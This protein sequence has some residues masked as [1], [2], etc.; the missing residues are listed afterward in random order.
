MN[1]HVRLVGLA[2]GPVA[3]LVL[4]RY[5]PAGLTTYEAAPPLVVQCG[6]AVAP[7][8]FEMLLDLDN[9]VPTYVQ[10]ERYVIV[11]RRA[12]RSSTA[13]VGETTRAL[14]AALESTW[15]GWDGPVAV[16]WV[17][18][19]ASQVKPWATDQRLRAAGLFDATK[20]MRHARDAARHALFAACHDA[21]VPDPLGFR[22]TD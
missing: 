22:I 21:G 4:L 1:G 11:G 19:S 15:L 14:V 7:P 2:P 13:G 6:S 3:G 5:V 12:S 20:G 9:Q 8:A 18:R 16:S 17:Q 10:V